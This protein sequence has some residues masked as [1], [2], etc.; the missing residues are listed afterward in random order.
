MVFP[1]ITFTGVKGGKR[2]LSDIEFMSI[3]E[4]GGKLRYVQGQ[5][6]TTTTLCTITANTGKDMYLA[7]AHV[8]LAMSSTGATASNVQ[9]KL[10]LN[11][12]LVEQTRASFTTY[13]SRYDGA[14]GGNSALEYDFKNVGRKVSAGQIIKIEATCPTNTV[15]SG[16]LVCFEETTGSSPKIT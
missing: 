11:G 1:F 5:V 8:T 15:V 13:N 6:T 14:G 4:F 3:K 10:Y 12:T 16:T 2:K 7:K 9:A